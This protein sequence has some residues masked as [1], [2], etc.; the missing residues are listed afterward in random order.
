MLDAVG[1][2]FAER[3]SNWHIV[4]QPEPTCARGGT[5]DGIL[6]RFIIVAP[7]VQ[8]QR[9][10]TRAY[11]VGTTFSTSHGTMSDHV[12]VVARFSRESTR[13][14]GDHIPNWI[15]ASK[16]FCCEVE[17]NLDDFQETADPLVDIERAKEV[18]FKCSER[19]ERCT[20]LFKSHDEARLHWHATLLRGICM[21]YAHRWTC[22]PQVS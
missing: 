21:R 10:R 15:A 20:A 12:R 9:M 4:P 18:L 3:A 14:V 16:E 11:T 6:D 17:R 5:N 22:Y 19:V 1:R 2:H 7:I 13:R 8:I